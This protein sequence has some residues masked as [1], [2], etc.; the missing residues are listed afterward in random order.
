MAVNK[1]NKS[2]EIDHKTTKASEN[3]SLQRNCGKEKLR[4]YSTKM[5]L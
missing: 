2:W 1:E 3:T 4:K 5:N